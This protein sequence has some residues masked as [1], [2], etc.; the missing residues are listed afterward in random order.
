MEP[1]QP[2]KWVN[3]CLPCELGYLGY[4]AEWFDKQ[5]GPDNGP[6]LLV[7]DQ[8][9]WGTE[10]DLG[11]IFEVS[12]GWEPR[13]YVWAGYIPLAEWENVKPYLAQSSQLYFPYQSGLN[14]NW[15]CPV[16]WLDE[17]SDDARPRLEKSNWTPGN[18][19]LPL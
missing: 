10:E 9:P 3:V 13:Y 11:R 18:K 8:E 12:P 1:G 17:T 2:P 5:I 7:G 16:V 15:R 14:P 4:G 6:V 19:L